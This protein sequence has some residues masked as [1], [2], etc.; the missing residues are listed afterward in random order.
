MS[1]GVGLNA[2]LASGS[3]FT[4]NVVGNDVVTDA[5]VDIQAWLADGKA[6]V[7]DVFAT[8]CGPCWSF[9]AT[10]WLEAISEV[11]GEHGTDQ[12]RVVG[13]EADPQTS[14]ASIMTNSFGE[15]G[16]WVVNPNTLEPLNYNIIDQPS[17]LND[18]AIA[19]FPTLYIIRPDGKVLEV[20]N[21]FRYNEAYWLAALNINP[22]ANAFPTTLSIPAGARFCD[23]ITMDAQD[24]TIQNV[25]N[26][27]LTN[28]TVNVYGNG[29]MLESVEYTGAEL[30]VFESATV[31]LSSQ[32][33]NED[34]EIIIGVTE[35]DGNI[36]DNS[37]SGS[38]S[39]SPYNIMSNTF[40]FQFTTDFYPGET[41]WL[42]LDDLG[43]ILAQ[44]GYNPGNEDNFGG[45]GD[46]ANKTF[47]YEITL[48]DNASCLTFVL[49]DGYGDGLTA[50][51]TIQNNE[52]GFAIIDANGVVKEADEGR[53]FF[54][55]YEDNVRAS[56]SSAIPALDELESMKI[57]PN[58]VADILNLELD[59]TETV[60]YSVQIL[61]SYGQI[62]RDLGRYNG[63]DLNT[64]VDI[65]DLSAGMYMIS[66]ISEQG[67]KTIK[68]NKI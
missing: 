51:D 7:V 9:H 62:V 55:S 22:Q 20:P 12:V 53:F 46:D 23:E 32:V 27:P 41:D 54:S 39:Q 50:W 31:S 64:Q 43:N 11:L 4:G 42:L 67:Q 47:D 16:S 40:T 60:N 68:F 58:P 13:V 44:D 35:A 15:P 8:W 28:A 61:D 24:V 52:P 21:N 37:F 2:Q 6:V 48:E 65:V 14:V 49:S 30:G 36:V 63:S 25:G 26:T 5:K 10:G 59:F 38:V 33:F 17:A 3:T 34:T 56:N 1:V 66:V 19:Y 45:G 29:I 57:F 18:L